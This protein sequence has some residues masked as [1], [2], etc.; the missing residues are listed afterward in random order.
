MEE[1]RYVTKVK[2]FQATTV[3]KL[4]R[5]INNFLAEHYWLEIVDIKLSVSE[6]FES[7]LIIYRER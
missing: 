4:E 3:V 7:A 1:R 2:L 5:A 6:M